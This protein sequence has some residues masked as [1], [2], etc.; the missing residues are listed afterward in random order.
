[1]N[2][3][4]PTPQKVAPTHLKRDA[5][6]YV[7][8]S[9]L[10]QV[11]ENTESTKRQYALQ[12]RAQALGWTADQ[13]IV[14]D[15]DLGQSGAS[16]A[17]REGFQR[18]VTE[19]GMGRAGIVI[20]LEV[21]RLARNSSDWHRLLEICA[22]TKT[23]ILDEDGLYDPCSFNDRLLLGLK[24]TMSEAEL[25]ILGTRLHGGRLN[26][27]RRGELRVSLPA[28][29]VYD[30]EGRVQFDPDDQVQGTIRLLFDTFHRLQSALGTVKAFHKQG[31]KFPRRPLAGPFKGELFW[32]DLTVG[33]A[34]FVLHNPRYAGVYVFGRKPPSVQSVKDSPVFIP[35]AHPGYIS[36]N[37]FETNQECLHQNAL[38]TV[39]ENRVFPPR[40]GPALLQG[41]VFCGLCG[42]RMKIRYRI[43]PKALVPTYTCHGLG[44]ATRCQDVPG[45]GVDKAVGALLVETMTPLALEAALSVQA[46]LQTQRDRVE[47]LLR[48][49]VDRA[50]YEADL[51]RRR[52]LQV[53]PENRLVA[54]TLEADWNAKLRACTEAQEKYER[55]LRNEAV[56]LNDEQRQAVLGLAGDFPRL[57]HAPSTSDQD[58]KKM[59]RLLVEDITLVKTT[60]IA[61]KVRF[62]GGTTR[63]L[64]LPNPLPVWQ[65]RKTNPMVV[66]AIDHLLDDHLDGDVAQFLNSYGYKSGTGQTFT[67]L[68]VKEL[69]ERYGLKSHPERLA[70][71]GFLTAAA[72]K[73][74]LGIG[75]NTLR[76]RIRLGTLTGVRMNQRGELWFDPAQAGARPA[77]RRRH[78]ISSP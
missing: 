64:T 45:G 60:C 51:A 1:M 52:Y 49:T 6:L 55:D 63:C 44:G 67:T 36:W 73:A 30:G 26:K 47:R 62:K 20:G 77:L 8:Q 35:G 28:G 54:G 9:T 53:D 3:N 56:I 39:P 33:R 29:F 10:R 72:M 71:R 43:T 59:A 34:L 14:I 17:D 50:Q 23:L 69:R 57:W 22:V 18:L 25:H 41:L 15:S 13:V 38:A 7:R 37:Q 75:E 27:A 16:A 65:V 46:E 24:G 19:I 68:I 11:V 58:R 32:Q 2:M 78:E 66:Q 74:L 48:Q 4:P 76:K 40:Q 5:Y 70:D 31:L 21:S 61:V 42:R 12:T